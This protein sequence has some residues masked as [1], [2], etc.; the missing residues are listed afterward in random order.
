MSKDVHKSKMLYNRIKDVKELQ[1][2][3]QKV[4]KSFKR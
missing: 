3:I 1:K 2:N 4:Q